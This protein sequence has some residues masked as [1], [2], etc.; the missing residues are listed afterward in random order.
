MPDLENHRDELL[1]L[2]QVTVHD[3]AYFKSN[4]W[5]VTN[6]ALLLMAA[7]VG[8]KQLLGPGTSASERVILS[9][10]VLLIAA[11]GLAML[12]KLEQ[13]IQVRE[14]RLEAVR[15]K[16]SDAFRSAWEAGSKG[17]ESFRALWFLR[18]AIVVGALMVVW[19][20]AFV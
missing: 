2:Y 19:I 12:I 20:C 15:E 6:Y 17:S 7:I 13:S 9:I 11:A 8:V 1:V 18:A 3:L 10:L 16:L 4:Q 5:S 14:R